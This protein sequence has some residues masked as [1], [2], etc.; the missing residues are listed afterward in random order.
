MQQ[1]QQIQ[2]TLEIEIDGIGY[3]IDLELIPAFPHND[4]YSPPEPEGWEVLD[5]RYSDSE[6]GHDGDVWD[7]LWH[8]DFYGAVEQA[9]KEY[10]RE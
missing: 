4:P 2:V 9:L 3:E 10:W 1:I 6:D 8:T 5:S 7:V